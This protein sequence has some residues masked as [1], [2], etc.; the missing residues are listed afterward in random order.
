MS[1][2]KLIIALAWAT[3]WPLLSFVNPILASTWT[4]EWDWRPP[5]GPWKGEAKVTLPKGDGPVHGAGTWDCHVPQHGVF[6]KGR[7][8]IRGRVE[9][10]VLTFTP[11]FII[12]EFRV[13]GKKIPIS[14]SDPGLYDAHVT[15]SIRVKDGAETRSV[16]HGA[17][18]VWRLTGRRN[19][20]KLAAPV[21]GETTVDSF[22][23]NT[24]PSPLEELS[25]SDRN[26]LFMAASRCFKEATGRDAQDLGDRNA[27]N[28]SNV[29][30]KVSKA[31]WW[32]EYDKQFKNTGL[33]MR[34]TWGKLNGLN[35]PD[36]KKPRIL[37]N[38]DFFTAAQKCAKWKGKDAGL[39]YRITY[40]EEQSHLY[41]HFRGVPVGQEAKKAGSGTGSCH[42]EAIPLIREKYRK[43]YDLK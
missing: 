5:E 14:N 1:K 7:L 35:D 19:C 11:Q 37:M 9:K 3:L 40:L 30:P 12:L 36:A 34:E 42:H 15:E 43:K 13:H 18:W 8:V 25:A 31:A 10:D 20:W 28:K 17:A 32:E 39:A 16:S 2:G 26:E 23:P 29:V 21:P 22:S 27:L 38:P 41:L 4:L 24:A 33:D 6:Q